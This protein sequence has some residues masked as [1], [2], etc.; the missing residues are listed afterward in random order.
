MRKTKIICTLGPACDDYEILK[1]MVEAGMNCCRLNFSHGTHE[2]QL[3][4]INNIKKLRKELNVP[5]PILLDTK[6]PE[7]RFGNFE[8]GKVELKAGQEFTILPDVNVLGDN[9]K[10]GITY[11]KL[12]RYTL[13]G[14]KILVDDGKIQMMVKDVTEHK[15]IICEVLNDGVL[16]NHKSL[17]VPNVDIKM[18][19]LSDVD[20]SDIEFGLENDIDIIAASFA[21]NAY[22]ILAL[23][24]LLGQHKKDDVMIIAKIENMQ[25][26]KNAEEILAVSDGLM[27][28][29]GDLGVE[30][31]FDRLPALQK[32]LINKC[33]QNGKI[34][35]TATQMLESMTNNPRPTRAEVSDVANAV[36]DKTSITMLSGETAAGKYPIEAIKT[37]SRINESA[38]SAINYEHRFYSQHLLLGKGITSAIC[39]AAVETAFK[40]NAKAIITVTKGG[41][42][43]KKIAAYQPACPI[44]AAVLNEKAYHQLGVIWGVAPFKA[45]ELDTTDKI[46]LNGIRIAVESGLVKKGD[47][48]VITG[49]AAIG[50]GGTDMMQIYQIEEKDIK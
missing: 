8:G 25:G 45:E 20:I 13:N 22:D 1:Q 21:R 32:E 46:V 3:V 41:I 4:R 49:A 7:V 15:E 42:T 11:D 36:Y 12:Y 26:I 29:R 28:A 48:V 24:R 34:V 43:A 23:R 9:T 44:I 5:L 6:G 39:A 35:V 2:D 18:P 47:T 37:M 30:V 50:K 31:D 40:M 10:G 38:E 17:N 27:V 16:A 19:Y 33:Y 14:V